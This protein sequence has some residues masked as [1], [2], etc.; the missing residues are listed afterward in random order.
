MA[1]I[2]L[3]NQ[4]VNLFFQAAVKLIYSDLEQPGLQKQKLPGSE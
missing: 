1:S 3:L 2:K 4:I